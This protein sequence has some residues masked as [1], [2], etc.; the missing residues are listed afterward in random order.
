MSTTLSRQADNFS[1]AA[2]L[3]R[4]TAL[5]QPTASETR[6]SY[7][8]EEFPRDGTYPPPQMTKK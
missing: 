2:R 4:A 6:M 1:A 7:S 8:T 3:A 5:S